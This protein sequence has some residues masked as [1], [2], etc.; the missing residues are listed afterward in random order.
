MRWLTADASTLWQRIRD[1]SH[2]HPAR[3]IND[4][5]ERAATSVQRDVHRASIIQSATMAAANIGD[6]VIDTTDL[7]IEEAVERAL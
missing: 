6:H 4:D 2:G 5:L 7:S 1:R 3:L